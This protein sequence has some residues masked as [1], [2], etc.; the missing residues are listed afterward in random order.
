[1]PDERPIDP[2]P[3]YN[4]RAEPRFEVNSMVEV[5]I[6]YP[7]M[8][9][10]F[11]G[12]VTDLSK[13]GLRLRMETSLPKASQVQVKFGE[14]VVFGEVRFCRDLADGHFEAGL[15]IEDLFARS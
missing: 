13:N 14:V 10:P 15:H 6:R 9:G 12:A 3:E 1:M 7:S 11:R 5:F 4:R 2:P 8:A